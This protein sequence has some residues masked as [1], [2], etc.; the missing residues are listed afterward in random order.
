MMTSRE[1]DLP[2]QLLRPKNTWYFY[3][4]NSAG[5]NGNFGGRTG[6]ISGFVEE[7][8]EEFLDFY[9]YVCSF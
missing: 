7:F 6:G 9:G 3:S 4:D 8:V 1:N 2:S 5:S